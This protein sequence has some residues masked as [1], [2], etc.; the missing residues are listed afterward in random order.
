MR[1]PIPEMMAISAWRDI[2]LEGR[3]G[4]E[5]VVGCGCYG[6]TSFEV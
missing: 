2:G 3:E 1:F 4:R 5:V 6:L